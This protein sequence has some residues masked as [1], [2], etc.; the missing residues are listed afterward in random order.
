MIRVKVDKEISEAEAV[1]LL[2]SKLDDHPFLD[3]EFKRGDAVRLDTGDIGV[4]WGVDNVEGTTYVI[5]IDDQGMVR[6]PSYGFEL[7]KLGY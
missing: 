1:A 4:V 2:R 5:Y 3:M 6:D 7:T